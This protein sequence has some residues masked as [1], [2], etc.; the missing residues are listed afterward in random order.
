MRA[1]V[2]LAVR[3]AVEYDDGVGGEH[4]KRLC[5]GPHTLRLGVRDALDVRQGLFTG[6]R[7]LVDVRGSDDVRHR[8][9]REQR[10]PSR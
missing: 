4:R 10:A 1:I 7:R 2:R 6:L 8:D 9:L 3:H 5:V